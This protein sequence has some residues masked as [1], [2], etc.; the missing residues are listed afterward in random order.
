MSSTSRR[1]R[2]IVKLASIVAMVAALAGCAAPPHGVSPGAVEPPSIESFKQK[3]AG[4]AYELEMIAIPAGKLPGAEAEIGPFWMA[5]TEIVWDLYDVFVYELD[6]K[7]GDTTPEVDAIARPSRPYVPP[8]RGYGH[9]G[10]PVISVTHHAAEQFCKWLSAKTGRTFRLP[11]EQEWEYAC[12]AGSTAA[13]SFGDD[14]AALGDY[15]WFEDNADWKTQ[16]VGRK[17]PNAWG[18]HDMHGNVSEWCNAADGKPI[19]RGGNH[20]DAPEALRCD[21]RLAQDSSWNSSDPQIPKSRWWL[22]DCPFVGFR[23]VCVPEKAADS[24]T[25]RMDTDGKN[26]KN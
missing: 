12:R 18:L 20:L 15:A 16:P 5:K 13:Y 11:T 3:I 8:D 25:P 7:S 24:N 1:N 21:A 9:E 2:R 22:A 17:K 14:P 4:A 26:G 19:T 23:V 6:K 10:Y